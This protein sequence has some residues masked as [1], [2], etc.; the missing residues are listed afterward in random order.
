MHV[1][2]LIGFPLSHSFSKKYFTEKFS[3]EGITG[4]SY[5]LFPLPD[6]SLLPG[7]F[8]SQA[9]LRGLNV[10]IPYKQA[11]IPYIDQLHP[12]AA[13]I[14]AVNVIRIDASGTKTGYNSDYFGFIASLQEW[15]SQ[16]HGDKI[17]DAVL[18]QCKALVLG[19]GGASKAVKAALEDL[20]I[21][22]IPVSRQPEPGQLTYDQL[23]AQIL[24]EYPLIINT[25][26]L[27][28]SPDIESFPP[29]P[30][31]FL[32]HQHYLYDLVYNPEETTF[33]KKGKEKGA[34]VLNGLPMLYGQAEKS[35]EIWNA[36][37]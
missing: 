33:M 3:R 35:W 30:Y 16:I 20:H 14:G 29:I 28:M 15:F 11:V 2:G 6:I 25:T 24:Q 19:T 31:Q 4:A 12:A 8:Q 13:R 23:T 32:T 37:E 36:A 26:P 9:Q 1:F 21:P 22:F 10:T 34:H 27:G 7:L 18:K 5:E 17:A